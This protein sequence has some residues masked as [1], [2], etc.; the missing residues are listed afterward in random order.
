MQEIN[1]YE[2]LLK[3]F[4]DSIG[5]VNHQKVSFNEFIDRRI[6]KIFDEI[7][8][9]ALETPEMAEFKIRLGKVRIPK[10]CVK[11]ADGSVR[12]ITPIEARIR[13]LTYSSPIFVEMIPIINGVLA[14]LIVTLLS[15]LIL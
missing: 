12:A 7:G 13:D 5:F 14:M 8:E 15:Q 2:I 3:A 9:I 1:K 6:Q 10:P 11:E 4:K